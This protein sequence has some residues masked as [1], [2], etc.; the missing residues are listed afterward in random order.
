MIPR[1]ASNYSTISLEE[2]DYTDDRFRIS[3]PQ[4]DDSLARSIAKFGILV[5]PLLLRAKGGHVIVK[6]HN[7]LEALRDLGEVKAGCLLSDTVSLD[8]YREHVLE[9]AYVN[10][11]G[12]AGKL[13]SIQ[14]LRT[15]GADSPS[16]HNV[17]AAG[18]GIPADVFMNE[19]LV[20]GVRGLPARLRQFLDM[21]DI[22]FKSIKT[23]MML[24]DE[25]H[26]FLSRWLEVYHLRL[27]IFRDVVEMLFDICR[28]DGFSGIINDLVPEP[29][30]EPHDEEARLHAA[31]FTVRYPGFGSVMRNYEPLL[32]EYRGR[33][34]TLVLPPYLEGSSIEV[35]LHFDRKE[36][37]STISEKLGSIKPDDIRSLLD[38]LS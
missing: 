37:R 23:L 19:G 16:V 2:V 20:A 29:G 1:D 3:R 30:K 15:L 8:A 36:S 26:A 11:L 25:V 35:K 38:L 7:R 27:N 6:G 5:P 4:R 10:A 21:R 33:G 9:K 12:P 22:P 14:I 31:L 13:R 17:A 24:P 18:L 34:I 28:R 32:G